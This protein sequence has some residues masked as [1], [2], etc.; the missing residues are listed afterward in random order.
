M[1]EELIKYIEELEN[2][3]KEEY[4]RIK[5]NAYSV[6]IESDYAIT[7]RDEFNKNAGKNDIVTSIKRKILELL[8]KEN[9]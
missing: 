9:T 3:C 7:L 2:E 1:Q 8:E 5:S 6:R 4:N